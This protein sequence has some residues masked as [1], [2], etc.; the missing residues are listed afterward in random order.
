MKWIKMDKYLL[1]IQMRMGPAIEM[2]AAALLVNSA[3]CTSPLWVESLFGT[4]SSAGMGKEARLQHLVHRI[5][6]PC[7][8]V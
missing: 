3:M 2:A 4:G 1:L 7:T 5:V 6:T 8:G